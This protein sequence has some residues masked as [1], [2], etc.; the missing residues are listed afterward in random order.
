MTFTNPLIPSESIGDPFVVWHRGNYY[1]TGTFDARSLRV[2]RSPT[3]TGLDRGE[4]RTVWTAPASGPQSAQV[5]AP[6]L[7]RFD[8]R[9]YLYYTASDGVDAH[10][11]HYVLESAGDDPL[12][13]YTDRGLVHPD[14][15]RYAIDGSVLALPDGRRYWMYAAGGLWI[16]P[17]E[18]PTRAVGPGVKFVDGTH[19]WERSWYHTDAGWVKSRDSYWIEAPQTL[20]RGGRV[21]VAYSAGHTAVRDYHIGLLELVGRDPLSPASWMKRAEP[22]FGP[23]DATADRCAVHSTGHNSFTRSPDGTEDWLVYH[24]TDGP[25]GRYKARTVRAQPFTWH[26]DG[27]P[28]LGL[29]VPS[30]VPLPAPSGEPSR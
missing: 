23:C 29:P 4:K 24:A 7:W 26:D 5:W 3:L 13:P 16:A 28:D 22:L 18:S 6:E 8:G 11:R 21:F 17:M 10:H 9:W 14:W 1:L 25:D 19:E 30:G 2:W 15:D 20:L 27:T 12:G